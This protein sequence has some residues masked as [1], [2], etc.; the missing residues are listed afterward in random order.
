MII[1]IFIFSVTRTDRLDRHPDQR[2]GIFGGGMVTGDARDFASPH[3][4]PGQRSGIRFDTTENPNRCY[5]TNDT[6]ALA[7]THARE[8]EPKILNRV[9]ARLAILKH[10][11]CVLDHREYNGK[12]VP[13][14][15]GASGQVDDQCRASCSYDGTGD[16]SHFRYLQ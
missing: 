16:H 3:H 14:P 10:F 13:N 15:T 9:I 7:H 1:E 5:K 12:I 2:G 11:R 6:R 8:A 4:N